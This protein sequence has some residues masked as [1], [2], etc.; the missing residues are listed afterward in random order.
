MKTLDER[1]AGVT[2]SWCGQDRWPFKDWAE[3]YTCQRCRE[4]FARK[5]NVHLASVIGSSRFP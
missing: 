5:S 3:P 4:V 1:K 2:C